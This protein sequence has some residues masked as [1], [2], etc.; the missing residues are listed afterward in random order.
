ML[1][2]LGT[3]H[4]ALL[5][6]LAEAGSVAAAGTRLGITQS[7]ASHR[8]REAERRLNAPLVRRSSTGVTLTEEGERLHAFAERFLRELSRLE[9]DIESVRLDGRS[10]V[11]LGQATY[12]RFHW[13]PAFRD[14][15]EKRDPSLSFDLSGSATARPLGSLQDGI[16]DVSAVF[17]RPTSSRRFKWHW[18]ASD[19]MVAVM[20]PD[21]RLA[22][23]PHV[24][25]SLLAEERLFTYPFASDPGFEWETLV[26]RPTT[27]YRS[28]TS[29]PTPEAAID[30]LRA[31]YG[32]ALFSRWAIRPELA[33][34]TLIARPLGPE[35]L[36]LDWWAV[37]RADDPP[38]S[39]S[40][41]MV[42]VWLDWVEYAQRG[43]ATLSFEAATGVSREPEA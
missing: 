29:L 27:P 4:L 35:G 41:R 1:P 19:P 22:A 23:A 10:L 17:G 12:S 20:A 9:Q 5:I 40:S 39:P 25:S 36:S 31:G 6:A 13:I 28:V 8:L 2:R 3:N 24:D 7:A 37:T 34:G 21:H 11:R 26:G 14:F 38:D 30:L 16:V 32:V 33:D 42:A 18:L 15:L 43:F